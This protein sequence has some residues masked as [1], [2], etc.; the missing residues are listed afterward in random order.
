MCSACTGD[1]ED[2][3]ISAPDG[4]KH[5]VFESPLVE[6]SD[7]EVDAGTIE[8]TQP[9]RV[10]VPALQNGPGE[11]HSAL[12]CYIAVKVH[13]YGFIPANLFCIGL[14]VGNIRRWSK[15]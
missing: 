8:R 4:T 12:I 10:S 5:S 9:G 11:V 1:Y 7:G 6:D 2:P 13:Q 3:E 14:Y 15:A